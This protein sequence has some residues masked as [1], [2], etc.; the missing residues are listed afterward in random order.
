ML[1]LAW[2]HLIL[3][4]FCDFALNTLDSELVLCLHLIYQNAGYCFWYQLYCL[5]HYKK[6]HV[7]IW[8]LFLAKFATK[9]HYVWQGVVIAILQ[10][11]RSENALC[12][13]CHDTKSI[14]LQIGKNLAYFF[15]MFMAQH[16]KNGTRSFPLNRN[17]ISILW[18]VVHNN[19]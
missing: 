13:M 6:Y 16:Y 10:W 3:S 4:W 19:K 7:S 2:I 18:N 1:I 12:Y 17:T 9:M 5:W 8:Q 11:K 14:K 15:I